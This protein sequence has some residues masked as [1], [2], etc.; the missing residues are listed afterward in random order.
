M[1]KINREQA[2]LTFQSVE[3]GLSQ[4]EIIEQSKCLIF[5]G[6]LVSAFNDELLCQAKSPFGTDFTGA[7]AAGPLVKILEKFPEEELTVEEKEGEL[8]I[9]GKGR[10]AGVRME[11]KIELPIQE[12]VEKPGSWT[13]LPQE[14]IEAVNMVQHCAGH[15]ENKFALTCLHI[16]PKW[17][18]ACDRLQ[19]CR[20]RF[21]TGMKEAIL[22]RYSCIK[23]VVK[24]AMMEM[25]ETGSWI[26][27]RNPSGLL[28]SCR[29][30]IDEYPDLS[31]FIKTKGSPT[32]LPKGLVE[33]LDRAE[34][35]TGENPEENKVL[36]TLK[37]GRITIKGVGPLGWY[38]EN[39]K[40]DYA[41][42]P[43]EFIVQ[44]KILREIVKRHTE[45]QVNPDMLKVKGGKW[46]YL[47]CL[48]RPN[49][50]GRP[51]G[52]QK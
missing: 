9:S 6:D 45:C 32:A 36:I 37:P 20:W 4:R 48:F 50:N 47:S 13:P 5:Q 41:G 28:M 23:H 19:M 46:V 27:F 17:I 15:D 34:V 22:V 42:E 31:T 26:H 29:R 14:F 3:P 33:G 25:S 35:F 11:K 1:I 30:Y 24:L 51:E 2:L 7:V 49:T 43:F 12:S 8:V 21:D 52:D 44:V 40:S 39:K 18:E 38:K 10:S 16:H